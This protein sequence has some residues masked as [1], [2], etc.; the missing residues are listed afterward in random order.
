VATGR[1]FP[2]C[3]N[4]ADPTQ[5]AIDGSIVVWSD[6]RNGDYD[7]YG[8]DLAKSVEFPVYVGPGEQFFPVVSGNLVVWQDGRDGQVDIWGVYIPEPAALSLL[9]LGGL[10]ILGRRKAVGCRRQAPGCRL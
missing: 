9:A 6:Q 1:E 3:T 4:D 7:I 2:I 8:Y 10:A 5:P